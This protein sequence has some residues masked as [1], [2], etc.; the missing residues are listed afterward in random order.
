LSLLGGTVHGVRSRPCGERRE[1]GA[2]Y[3][4]SQTR[5]RERSGFLARCQERPAVH[6]PSCSTR[7]TKAS[8][9][10]ARPANLLNEL[11]TNG[12]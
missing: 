12:I 10:L 11:N 9:T 6:L 8:V 2:P 5:G 4:V 1:L 3:A 7:H